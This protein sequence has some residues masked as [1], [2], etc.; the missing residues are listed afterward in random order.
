M[1][2][3][4]KIIGKRISSLRKARKMSQR[5]LIV[6]LEKDYF[7][8]IGRNTLSALETGNPVSQKIDLLL[9]LCDIFNC[10]LGYLLGEYDLPT[11]RETDI[12]NETGL[13]PDSVR[14]MLLLHHC[15]DNLI[16]E[17]IDKLLTT[18]VPVPSSFGNNTVVGIDGLLR[19]IGMYLD[20]NSLS[21]DKDITLKS[22][23]SGG[24]VSVDGSAFAEGA[25]LH[26]IG[27]RLT[28]YRMSQKNGRKRKGKQ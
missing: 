11:G 22:A 4:Y 27:L 10:E 13:S 2:Y 8:S 1:E 19:L 24:S 23:R 16:I 3:N 26:L 14:K 20:D 9:A 7:I 28:E 15:K 12:A 17:T 18:V 21:M 6:R 25:L 5:D